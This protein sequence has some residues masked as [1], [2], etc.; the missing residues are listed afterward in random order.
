M[1]A[2]AQRIDL[3]V[4]LIVDPRADQIIR[5]DPV[6]G[7]ASGGPVYAG[8]T[9]LVGENGPEIVTWGADGYVTPNHMIPREFVAPTADS[10]SGGGRHDV[11]EIRIDKE[12]IFIEGRDLAI[13]RG[14]ISAGTY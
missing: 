14:T 9:N 1:R 7:K 12:R 13:K 2:E 5:K 10:G 8:Q 6:F 3:V 11:I 4:A